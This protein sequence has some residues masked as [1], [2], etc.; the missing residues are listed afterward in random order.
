MAG[1]V[2]DRV[3]VELEAKLDRYDANVRRAEARFSTAARNIERQ[4]ASVERSMARS[5]GAIGNQLRGL[6][7]TFAAAFS[8]QQIAQLADGYTR[9]TNQL[10]VAGVEGQRLGD[11]QNDLY[12]IAQKYGVQLEG[13]GTLYGRLKQGA[14]EL[15]ASSSQ[16][17]EFT[18]GVAAALKIQGGAASESRGALL[19]LTQALGG[20]IV[21]AEEFNSI[22]EGARPILAAV[23]KGIDRFGGSVARLRREVVDG[24]VT[25]QE[26]FE[27]FL[28]GSSDL[29]A[30][31][32]QANLTI[33]NSF[34]VLNNALGK[35]IGEADDSL[36]AT[37]RISAAL[38]ALSENLD[39]VVKA[40]AVIATIMGARWISAMVAAAGATGA[41][42]TAIFAMQARAL[43][44]ATT[45][46]ALALTS[47]AAGASML[48]AFGGPVGL[49][50]AALAAGVYYLST[51]TDEAGQAS[52]EYARQQ[53]ILADMQKRT[54]DATDDLSPAPRRARADAVANAEALRQETIQYLANARA[55]L[56]AAR[57]KAQRTAT[58][59]QANVLTSTRTVMGAGAGYD[60][61]LSAIRRGT[62]QNAQAAANVKA[63]QENVKTAEANLKEL[64]SALAAP[65]A[66]RPPPSPGKEKK[67]KA[68]RAPS[69]KIWTK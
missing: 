9:F 19:Q 64:E 35:Y 48:A 60:P 13:L 26:F 55:A 28:K 3:I 46:E 61:T 66:V 2:A 10:K 37:E 41:L 53:D 51:R 69:P 18:T 17:M 47:R 4:A 34:Q 1:V 23:A 7:A 14:T 33:A 15:G 38:I 5:T 21:R 59:A 27:G 31:A 8:V 29:Q 42:S 22:N 45:M 56:I 32:E 49:A 57:A 20:E 43:G 52:G 58:E 68:K 67:T 11:V 62:A 24:K 44:A 12:A 54:L 30:R 25:S 16:L 6:A 40:L 63:A 50:V 65:P 39:L 36:S